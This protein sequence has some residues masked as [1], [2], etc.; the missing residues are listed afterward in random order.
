MEAAAQTVFDV[1]GAPDGGS[2]GGE[3]P[4][5]SATGTFTRTGADRNRLAERFAATPIFAEMLGAWD[6]PCAEFLGR[7]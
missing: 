6:G 2:G 3:P 7:A 5:R 4:M 1:E